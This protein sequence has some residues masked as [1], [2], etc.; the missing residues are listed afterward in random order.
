[1]FERIIKV[2]KWKG[3]VGIKYKNILT[4]AIASII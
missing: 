1:M 2:I 3:Y 4:T